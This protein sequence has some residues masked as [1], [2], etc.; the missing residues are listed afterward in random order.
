MIILQG[1]KLE[2]SFSG[3]VLFQNISLQVD[4]RDRIALVGPNGAGKSTLLKLL[5]GEETPTSGEVN[6]K[7]DLT[8]S[9]LAQN[10]RFASDKTIYEEM[11]KVFEDLRQNEKRLRQ[12]EMDMATVSGQ[13][14]TRLMTD[15]DLL[16]E[17]FR[18]QGGFTYESDIKAI[19]NGFKFDESMWQMTIAE[20]SGGQ[21]TRL[22]L[23]KMLLEK[24]ELL[25]LDEPTNHLDIETIA[26]LENYLANYQGALIIVSHDRYFLDKV[27]TVTLDLT[28][29]GLDR[30][31]G[32]YSRFMTLK[33]EKLV[34]E[35][36]QFD[37]QQKEIAKLE[38]FV[39]KNIV[40]TSTTKRAQARRKQLE[41]IERLDKPTSA[42]KSAHMTFQADKPSGNVVL[43]V[44][45]AAIGYNQHVLSEPINLD[46][47]KLDAIAIVGPNGIGKSTLIKS[48]IGQIPFIKGEVR[49]GANVEIGYY[50]QTQS[51]LTSSNTVLEELWQD[52]STT[53]EV[54]IRNRLGAF[55]FSGDDVKKSVAMLSGGEK[56]RLLLAKLSMENNNFLV[57]D[58]P[59]NHLDID[60]KE[61]LE[62][63]LIDFDGTLLF[64]S[65]DRYFINRLATKVLEITE[66]GSTL[67]LGDYDYYLEKKAELEELARLAAGETV[68]ETK[69]AS[70]TDYQLQKA[71]QK[72]RRRLTRRYEE[73]EARLKTIE[74]RI[75]AIQED[76]HASNDTAQLIAWQKE[77]DQL[78]QEQ[79][80]LMEEWETIAEQIES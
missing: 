16:T 37:K 69:E 78:D 23:A 54:D 47:H 11:L 52:F 3:D 70:A 76:M 36:K 28:P 41:K 35:E 15:Y 31:V 73:I 61:V 49:Y 7:K 4:E 45:K 75:C 67:Y 22:A 18:Q 21:N 64:V 5:V 39:Q 25:V 33:A 1:N 13:D 55:L 58:E 77:W 63:A 14:L 74:E 56:A 57:L 17:H 66:N 60:S 9:Y 26:W 40:R 42:R 62:N 24:P 44:E 32:N 79:E 50:D 51:H 59:T 10:S 38:D 8:L 65:H 6:T 30:Y 34:A 71:N 68:E 53:P 19:L 29:H 46:V 80:A 20:L 12:M 2:R 43:T 48:V 72:E 27:A